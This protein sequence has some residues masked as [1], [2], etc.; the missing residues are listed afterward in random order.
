MD[1]PIA[2]MFTN[3]TFNFKPKILKGKAE[4]LDYSANRELATGLAW[5]LEGRFLLIPR[6]G[7]MIAVA[8]PGAT[9][10]ENL[11]TTR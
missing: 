8:L 3:T 5:A 2:P 11:V 10:L 9:L 6:V 4:G 1:F 7:I